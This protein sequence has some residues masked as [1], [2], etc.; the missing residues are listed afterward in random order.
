MNTCSQLLCNTKYIA[1]SIKT[2]KDNM[3]V[4]VMFQKPSGYLPIVMSLAALAVVLVYLALFGV[5]HQADEGAAAHLWQILMCG[6]APIVA[7]FIIRWLPRAPLPALLV[8]AAQIV[9]ALAAVAP[10]WW[11]RL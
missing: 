7:F 6:Q 9:T 11:F 4:P 2:M 3:T 1:N 10:V 8:L 5:P